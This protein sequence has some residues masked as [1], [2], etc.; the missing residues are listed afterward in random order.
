MATYSLCIICFCFTPQ[1]Q[2]PTGVETPGIQTFGRLVFLLT[3][4]N[5]LRNLGE[6]TSLGQ[7]IWIFL[8]NILN[9]F[10]LFPLVFQLLYLFPSLRK[11]K[12]VL[13]LSFILSLGI[14]CTQLVLD[15]FFDF[16]RVFE[17]DDLWTNTLGGY[18]AWVLYRKLN[19]TK[20]TKELT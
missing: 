18:L 1:P 14:E 8:Q 7:V 15:F 11:T 20:H 10:L 6:V 5:S 4:L 17:I 9:V 19:V 3:P 12:R 2:L 16:N 13:L